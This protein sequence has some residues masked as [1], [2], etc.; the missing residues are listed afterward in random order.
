MTT[1][2]TLNTLTFNTNFIREAEFKHGRTAMVALPT[3][4]FLEV[5]NP[6]VLGI[7]QLASTPLEYQLLGVGIFG[8]S[9]VSQLLNSY[10]FPNS[11]DNWFK[12]KESH[13]PGDYAF[14]PLNLSLN[15]DTELNV[16]RMAMIGTVGL[17]C[18]ELVT[19]QN[20]F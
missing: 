3:I 17:M 9:E 19:N 12:L 6:S 10:E 1:L 16:G 7:N 13:E 2:L 4:A 8:C 18:Q 11:T 5:V 20:V 15:K 14:N